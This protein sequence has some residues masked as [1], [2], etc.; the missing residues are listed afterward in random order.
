MGTLLT[1]IL[2]AAKAA[3]PKL[4]I[5]ILVAAKA[6]IAKIILLLTGL[7]LTVVRW[8]EGSAD[9]VMRQL[10]AN[11]Q[12]ALP[13]LL[14]RAFFN[15]EEAQTAAGL[16]AAVIFR[17]FLGY[18]IAI[19]VTASLCAAFLLITCI[20][21]VKRALLK[22][23]PYVFLSFQHMREPLAVNV[24]NALGQAGFR[25]YRL[26]YQEGVAHQHVVTE[27]NKAI[28]R[29]DAVVCLPGRTES[30]VDI[31][32]GA[33]THGFKPIAFALPSQGGSLPNSADK[34]YP[35][36]RLEAIEATHYKPLAAFL[37]YVVGDFTSGLQQVRNSARHPFVLITWGSAVLLLCGV[38]SALF[39]VSYWQAFSAT[40]ALAARGGAFA[41]VHTLTVLSTVCLLVVLAATVLLV[42]GYTL[43]VVMGV[44]RQWHAQRRAS[45]KAGTAD[46]A[47]DDWLGVIPGML[48]G[49]E[50]YE[51]LFDTAPSAHH[52]AHR[53]P[54]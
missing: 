15:S 39:L 33:A 40:E 46:F 38:L 20:P 5:K 50:L 42:A 7:Y 23:R 22:N 28:R 47:R 53:S 2:I 10:E 29:C 12:D 25:I 37:H 43:L 52:E 30:Y 49:S 8:L 44:W 36:F 6:A 17:T 16:M 27:T 1:K 18:S 13:N 14:L 11:W 9:D 51:C 3:I 48:P 45:L 34:R 35:V 4:L 21:L 19:I 24:E 54:A 26:P 32:V 41:E 31:E